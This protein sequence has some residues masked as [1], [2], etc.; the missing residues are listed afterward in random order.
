MLWKIML[1]S[2]KHIISHHCWAIV[3]NLH[4]IYTIY[5]QLYIGLLPFTADFRPFSGAA[6]GG[7]RDR[8]GPPVAPFSPRP[9]AGHRLP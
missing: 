6:G 5:T 2:V 1:K 8:E 4:R 3:W 9:S 7:D